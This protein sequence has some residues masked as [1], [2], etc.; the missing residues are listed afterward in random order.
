MLM[1][2]TQVGNEQASPQ[3]PAQPQPMPLSQQ[4]Q[5]LLARE[6]RGHPLFQGMAQ[7]APMQQTPAVQPPQPP[8]QPAMT[9]P[10]TAQ[11]V[12]ASFNQQPA[13]AQP[14]AEDV[15]ASSGGQ[16]GSI[17]AIIIGVLIALALLAGAAMFFL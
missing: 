15:P 10:Q 4:D 14:I 16:L 12:P 13:P 8:T 2:N 3:A 6:M 1:D 5:E 7:P 17:I 9:P 11:P